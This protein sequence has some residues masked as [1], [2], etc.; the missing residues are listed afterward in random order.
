MLFTC[1]KDKKD[2]KSVSNF[3]RQHAFTTQSLTGSRMPIVSMPSTRNSPILNAIRKVGVSRGRAAITGVQPGM[4]RK[5]GSGVKIVDADLEAGTEVI[6]IMDTP[7]VFVPF[8]P[9]ADDILKMALYGSVNDTIIAATTFVNYLFY[10]IN[11]VYPKLCSQ[12][13]APTNDVNV[14][15][16]G[17]CQKTGG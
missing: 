4:T 13:C 5:I 12:Y 10:H 2:V 15:F 3:A 11:K 8:L 1:Y 17:I 16:D 6:Y 7:G 9:D 14:F